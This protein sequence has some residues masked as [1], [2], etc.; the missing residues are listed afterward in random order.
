MD[1][2]EAKHYKTNNFYGIGHGITDQGIYYRVLSG[3]R[4]L[5]LVYLTTIIEL[6]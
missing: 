3:H 5:F 6:N 4:F 1:H 2:G